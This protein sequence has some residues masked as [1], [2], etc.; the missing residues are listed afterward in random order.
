IP[1]FRQNSRI[2][3]CIFAICSFG[4][5]TQ[6]SRVT[7][8]F[9][10][11]HTFVI[12]IS[13]NGPRAIASISCM[14]RR[15]T[16]A[17]TMSPGATR[18]FPLDRAST[19]SDIVNP[20]MEPRTGSLWRRLLKELSSGLCP[21]RRLEAHLPHDRPEL[22]VAHPSPLLLPLAVH[23]DE[24]DLFL[25][26]PGLR[27]VLDP[28]D[29]RLELVL[30]RLEAVLLQAVEHGGAPRVLPEDEPP[31]PPDPLGL[32]RLLPAPVLD[33]ALPVD[34]RLLGVSV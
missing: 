8:I 3:W 16:R 27:D 21:R 14:Y 15:S 30:R 29:D 2:C 6:W 31:L 26:A 13:A 7:T 20:V 19:F 22:R 10:G 23:L 11:S 12:P 28:R 24:R 4:G 34:A 32:H 25:L 33:S 17:S 9:V 1:C 5:G 18:S